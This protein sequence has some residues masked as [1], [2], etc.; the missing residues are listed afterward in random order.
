MWVINTSIHPIYRLS[1]D[2]LDNRWSKQHIILCSIINIVWICTRIE[3]KSFRTTSRVCS[4]RNIKLFTRLC[5]RGEWSI[6][7]THA[8][9]GHVCWCPQVD[10][11]TKER[12][13]EPEPES[14]TG[15][16][17]K[18][19]G[20]TEEHGI[21]CFV[22]WWI[23]HRL[24]DGRAFV[25]RELNTKLKTSKTNEILHVHTN[26][27]TYNTGKHKDSEEL[28]TFIQWRHHETIKSR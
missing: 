2:R 19:C 1:N 22:F 3:Y 7:T 14:R 24:S 6:A 12:K 18:V 5:R 23:D 20:S 15:R 17:K 13:H 4:L 27:R 11:T 9:V 16:Q 8:F 10:G 21:Q 25:L 28:W 26:T